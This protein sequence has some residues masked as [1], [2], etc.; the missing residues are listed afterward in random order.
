VGG[1]HDLSLGT[2]DG[3]RPHFPPLCMIRLTKV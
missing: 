1:N 3:M 2:D